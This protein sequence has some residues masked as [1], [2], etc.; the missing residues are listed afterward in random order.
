[1]SR[2]RWLPIPGFEGNYEVSDFGRVRGVD[3]VLSDGRRWRG[4]I[5]AQK[6]GSKG[7]RSVRLCLAGKHKFVGVHVLVLL[8]FKGPKPLKEMQGAHNDGTPANTHISNLR[9]D[10]VRGNHA[11]KRKHGTLLVGERNVLA[12]LTSN[13]VS[14]IRRLY[15]EGVLGK[16]LA[17][18]FGVTGANISSIIRN[19]TWR[20][21]ADLS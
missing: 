6:I 19:K 1:M 9:W 7:H 3:R 18:R 11:D 14:A 12:K 4:G 2:E 5:R 15:S 8:A 21:D 20:T 13:D 17:A 10:T 16:D